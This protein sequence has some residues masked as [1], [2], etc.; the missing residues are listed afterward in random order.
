M[1]RARQP[2]RDRNGRD[3]APAAAMLP[4]TCIVCGRALVEGPSV[5]RHHWVPRSE[6]GAAATTI[7][8]VCHRM[9]HRLF[10]ERELA[11]AYST[12][13]AIRAHPE[14]QRFLRWIQRRPADYLDYP[15]R[16]RR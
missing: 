10:S 15:R 7:H 14:M 6:G 13:E 2:K 11:R 4:E 1:G 3:P 12:P 9:I 8:T 5:D 16:P